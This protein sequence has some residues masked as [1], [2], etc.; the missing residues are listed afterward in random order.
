MTEQIEK[1]LKNL[2]KIDSEAKMINI[3][4]YKSQEIYLQIFEMK[5]INKNELGRKFNSEDGYLLILY[6]NPKHFFLRRRFKKSKFVDEFAHYVEESPK[7]IVMKHLP[8]N[9]TKD[10]S[11]YIVNLLDV[12]RFRNIECHINFE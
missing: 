5:W 3:R 11:Y 12:I 10:V 4:D 7:H 1:L 9:N 2:K 8:S 6:V